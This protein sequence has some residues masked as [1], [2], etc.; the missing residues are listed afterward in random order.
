MCTREQAHWVVRGLTLCHLD[1][2]LKGLPAA[3]QFLAGDLAG[4][5]MLLVRAEVR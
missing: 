5:L 2:T 1:A 4:E 3:Q